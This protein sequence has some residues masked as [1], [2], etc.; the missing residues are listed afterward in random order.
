MPTVPDY[1]QIIEA[2]KQTHGIRVRRWRSHM[3]GCAW[4]VVYSDGSVINWIE[5]PRPRSPVSL[6]IFLHE[7]GHHVIGF[8]RYRLRCEE[9]YHAWAWAINEMI[10]QGVRPD[11][12]TMRRFDRSMRYAVAKAR[13][14]GLKRLPGCLRSFEPMPPASA[15]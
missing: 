12:R 1:G 13:R 10:R 9:E 14:R 15:A 4:R 8:S 2:A 7:V 3:S 6:A 11:L 5:S